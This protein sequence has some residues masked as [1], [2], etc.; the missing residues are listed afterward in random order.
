MQHKIRKNGVRIRV[1]G[2]YAC[3]PRVDVKP[4]M[5][6][7]E[8]I[9]PTAAVGVLDSIYWKPS[10]KWVLDKIILM[11]E[12]PLV[13]YMF[14]GIE[15]PSLRATFD[16][17]YNLVGKSAVQRKMYILYDVDYIIEA[18]VETIGS[19]ED[20]IEKHYEIAKRR[21]Q[22]GQSFVDACLGQKCF[23]AEVEWQEDSVDSSI[24][25]VKF[26]GPLFFKQFNGNG[27]YDFKCE[28]ANA[29][30]TDGV[31]NMHEVRRA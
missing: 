18:H 2:K 22:K 8:V 23:P 31:I 27:A 12:S 13:S 30:M 19:S 11:K 17:G 1:R 15:K 4:E 26:I 6:S 10:M 9:T 14:N 5:V 29:I 16:K 25:G 20:L 3:F 28:Y 21:I 24:K 7:Y